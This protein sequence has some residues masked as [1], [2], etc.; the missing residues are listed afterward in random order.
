M[1]YDYQPQNDGSDVNGGMPPVNLGAPAKNGH[2]MAVTSLILA[3]SSIVLVFLGC[4]CINLIPAILSIVF[5]LI[6]KKRS[7]KMEGVAIAGLVVGIICVVL[8]LIFIGFV[9]YIGIAV[10]NNPNGAI[11][12][13][14]DDLFMQRYGISFS[15]YM[16]QILGDAEAAQ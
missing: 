2:N 9:I 15:E 8:T 5:A 4:C 6:S 13:R 16:N 3:V 7:G 1:N 14:L 11:A 10:S 12:Q